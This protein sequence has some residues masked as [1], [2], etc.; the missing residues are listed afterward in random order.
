MPVG[1]LK[2]KFSEVLQTV[3]QGGSVGITYGKAKKKIAVLVPFK[4]YAGKN[5]IKL[6]CLEGKA[7]FKI[8]HDFKITDEEFLHP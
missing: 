3:Q 8:A 1:E 5:K 6:G 4:K 7:T 2:A